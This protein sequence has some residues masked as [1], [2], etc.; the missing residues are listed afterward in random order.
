MT[1][2]DSDVVIRLTQAQA[3]VL[4]EWL[5]RSDN[6]RPIDDPAEERVLWRVEGQ[7]ESVLTQ[8][9]AANYLELLAAAR[10]EV[11]SKG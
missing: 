11:R 5:V 1:T 3:L 4:F 2:D 9:L 6:K 8:P 10:A 7:L